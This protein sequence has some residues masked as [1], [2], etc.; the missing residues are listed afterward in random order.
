MSPYSILK[1]NSKEALISKALND[2]HIS[3]EKFI[4][5]NNASKEYDV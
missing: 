3:H 4:S 2:S 5:L 1:L